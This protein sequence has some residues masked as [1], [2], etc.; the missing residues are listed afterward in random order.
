M[1]KWKY[2]DKG[3][4]VSNG[5]EHKYLYWKKIDGFNIDI[6]KDLYCL[7]LELEKMKIRDEYDGTVAEKLYLK[8]K[9]KNDYRIH[10]KC[11]ECD[12]TACGNGIAE[13]PMESYGSENKRSVKIKILIPMKVFKRELEK[14][15]RNE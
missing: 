8:I 1:K 7:V 6:G 13:L 2:I 10:A 9:G 5:F 11:T 4:N 14:N 12:M 3:I 15:V